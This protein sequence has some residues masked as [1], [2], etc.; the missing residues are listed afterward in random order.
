MKRLAGEKME[1]GVR[2]TRERIDSIKENK[3]RIE[4]KAKV[5]IDIR[6]LDVKIKGEAVNVHKTVKILDAIHDGFEIKNS[7]KLLNEKNQL[8]VVRLK[9]FASSGRSVEKMKGRIIGRG[10]RTKELIEELSNVSVSVHEDRVS[11]I[12]KPEEVSIAKKAVG[13]L[14]NGKPHGRVYRYLEQNQPNE[15]MI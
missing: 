9:D 3:D 15:R 8:K 14:I 6:G 12:G 13:M 10:G 4:G 7:F 11:F 2:F 1:K 5:E